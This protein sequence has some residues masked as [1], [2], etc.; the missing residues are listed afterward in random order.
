MIFVNSKF[1]SFRLYFYFNLPRFTPF[2]P[3]FS[4][5]HFISTSIF[6]DPLSF[7]PFHFL[8]LNIEPFVD[9]SSKFHCL[10]P[11]ISLPRSSRYCCHP[12]YRVYIQPKLILS[13]ALPFAYTFNK[14]NRAHN[15]A[16]TQYNPRLMFCCC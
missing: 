9:Y 14:T 10:K 11:R 7:T 3:R 6:L 8:S 5:I 15:H 16:S 1:S 12:K 13:H 4:E 2:L